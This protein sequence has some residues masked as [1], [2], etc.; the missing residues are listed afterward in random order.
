MHQTCSWNA[1]GKSECG[2][3][4]LLIIEVS[5]ARQLYLH[6]R[7]IL[8]DVMDDHIHMGVVRDED[9]GHH[10]LLVELGVRA[11]RLVAHAALAAHRGEQN[12]G[13][14]VEPRAAR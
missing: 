14:E 12:I 1:S 7:I 2:K 11:G 13:V 3:T 10:D 4:R 8:R 6:T 5:H 9:D